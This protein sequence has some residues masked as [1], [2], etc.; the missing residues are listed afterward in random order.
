MTNV[1]YL[2]WAPQSIAQFLRIALMIQL[3][4]GTDKCPLR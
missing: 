2:A 4:T 3:S 1:V